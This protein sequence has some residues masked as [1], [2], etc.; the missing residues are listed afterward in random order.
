MLEAPIRAL[1]ATGIG[2]AGVKA[3]FEHSFDISHD[4]LHVIAGVV[5]QIAV[6]WAFRSTI[7]SW[8]PWLAVLSLEI[9]NELNDFRVEI[10]PNFAMQLGESVKD[11]VLTLLLPTLLLIVARRKSKLLVDSRPTAT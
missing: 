1:E 4:A 8:R 7:A 6:A 9:V 11:L 10:W 2:L 5:V 3:L